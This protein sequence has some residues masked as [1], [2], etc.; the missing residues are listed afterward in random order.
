MANQRKKHNHVS[1]VDLKSRFSGLQRCPWQYRF[2]SVVA[3][4]ICEIPQDSSKIRT[5]SSSRSSKV[6]DLSANRKRICNF[7]LIINS[8]FGGIS[9]RFRD[10]DALTRIYLVFI[11]CPS[12]T[13][14]SGGTAC[15]INIIY[16]PLKS[17]CTGL[18]LRCWQ[19]GS[20]F[21]C[22]AVVGSQIWWNLAKFR[23]KSTL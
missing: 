9:Y 21:S 17:T 22:L 10:I 1:C 6:I 4:Q 11:T 20:I 23:E 3:S 2:S 15:D 13:P 14:S 5:Y 18:Q 16:I 7:L 12:L 8:N 19:H